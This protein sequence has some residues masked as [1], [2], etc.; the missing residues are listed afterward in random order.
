MCV[1]KLC[2]M[3]LDTSSDCLQLT[4]PPTFS[5]DEDAAE[6]GRKLRNSCSLAGYTLLNKSKVLESTIDHNMSNFMKL[7][8]PAF[9]FTR[10]LRK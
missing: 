10:R 2:Y 7:C 5:T 9:S 8:T 1:S 6:N 3:V 4:W